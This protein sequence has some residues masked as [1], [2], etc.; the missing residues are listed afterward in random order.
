MYSFLTGPMLWVAM[1][2][3]FGGLAIRVVL[4]IRGLSQQLDRVAYGPHFSRGMQGAVHSALKWLVPF[5]TY[6][7]RAQPF[8]TVVFFLFH[9]GLVLVPLFLAGHNIIL[10]ERFGFSLPTL[11]MGVA[12]VLTVLAIIGGALIA[13]R[14][15]AL[16]EVRILTDAQDW[17][18]LGLSLALLVSGFIARLHLGDYETWIT[19]HIIF[20]EAVLILAPFT[21]LSH[22]AL[23]F[24]SR[25]QLGM[26]YAIKRGGA[27]RGPAFPW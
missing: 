25:G 9:I 17:F 3:F 4:Y 27:T 5:G 13:L 7:W 19:A 14:R 24:M 26:D 2:V 20:G 23:Y 12:D 8:F 21:K 22:I 10:E 1:L 15:V 16:T 18:I 11:P 6:S